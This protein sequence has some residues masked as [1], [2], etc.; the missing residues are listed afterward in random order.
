ALEMILAEKGKLPV[1]VKFC[2]EGEEEIGSPN[3]DPFVEKHQDLLAA[4]ALVVSDNPMLEKGQPTV[5]YGLRGLCGLQIDIKGADSDLH[6]GLYGGMVQNPIH[7][8]A[9]IVSSMHDADGRITVDD[10]YD[11]VMPLKDEEREAYAQLGYDEEKAKKDLGVPE[12][13]GESG[14][15]PLEQTWVRPTLELNGIYGGFQGEEIK[16]VLP[17]EA[18]AKIT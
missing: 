18:H 2:I 12:L 5:C 4:D 14:Y 16:T 11:D 3:L 7:A 17:S 6:S 13:F 8:L 1:N 10:F 9:D 15:S